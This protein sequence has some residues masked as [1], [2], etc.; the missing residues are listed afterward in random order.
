MNYSKMYY[1]LIETKKQVNR[2]KGGG[3]FENHQ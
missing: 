3:L 1:T 2:V